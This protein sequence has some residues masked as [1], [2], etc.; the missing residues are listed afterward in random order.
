[1]VDIWSRNR[2]L[3]DTVPDIQFV[4]E[5]KSFVGFGRFFGQHCLFNLLKKK[6]R[7]LQGHLGY[8]V[9]R[10]KSWRTEKSL[11]SNFQPHW[12][13]IYRRLCLHALLKRGKYNQITRVWKYNERLVHT[14]NGE[15]MLCWSSRT[16]LCIA[17][18][19]RSLLSKRSQPI[20]TTRA[21]G[22]HAPFQS[23]K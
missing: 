23:A 21:R 19:L 14:L 16:G 11:H 4:K 3:F 6:N 20:S 7:T 12:Q 13:S 1:M 5:I 22:L 15:P 18:R 10:P 9:S 8:V 2:K 17:D